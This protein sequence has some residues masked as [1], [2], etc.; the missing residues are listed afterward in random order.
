VAEYEDLGGSPVLAELKVNL[1]RA[2]SQLNERAVAV[3]L[4]DQALEVAEH[5]NHPRL[6]ARGLV[7]KGAAMGG[8][9]RL[10]EAIAL[11]RAGEEVARENEFIGEVLGS[12]VVRGYFLSEVDN[13][14]ALEC[15]QDGLALARRVGHR[16]FSRNFINNIGYTSFLTGD[17]D[18][19][20]AELDAVLAEDL[21]TSGRIWL[22]S[23][24]LIIRVSRGEDV[25]DQLAEMERL[26]ST[27]DDPHVSTAPSDT[28]ANLAQAQGRLED[29]QRHWLGA[30]GTWS[31][32]EPAAYYQAA[33]PALW[34]R[35]L[36]K[37][38]EYLAGLDATGFH[39]PVVEVRRTNLRAA[40]AALEG[41]SREAVALYKEAVTAWRDLKVVWEE[42]LTGLD[43]ATV[44]DQSDPVVQTAIRSTRDI[45]TRL[46][47]RPYLAR[48]EAVLAA[49]PAQGPTTTSAAASAAAAPSGL[50]G[51][52]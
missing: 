40:V 39:G 26:A 10:R 28:R 48:L 38:R 24:A 8:L 46:G 47:A 43:M 20:L 29:A 21:D 12:L 25:D 11:I 44:L 4:A 14:Q 22:L 31:S 30:V 36:E 9:G 15:Y 51:S 37:V 19:G 49:R 6:L 50:V 27:V 1:A 23:N 3:H 5:G 33:R 17:W 45:F 18:V 32:Q 52:T 7:V 16:A 42:A 41:R 13:A 34:A 35:D 2:Q